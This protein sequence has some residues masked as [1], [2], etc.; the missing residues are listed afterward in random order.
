M[1]GAIARA[2]VSCWSSLSMRIIAPVL[3]TSRPIPNLAL[4]CDPILTRYLLQIDPLSLFCGDD[5]NPPAKRLDSQRL[6]VPELAEPHEIFPVNATT[7]PCPSTSTTG[8]RNNQIFIVPRNPIP[9]ELLREWASPKLVSY[10][11]SRAPSDE[12][13]E[14]AFSSAAETDGDE[15][16]THKKNKRKPW[17]DVDGLEGPA[18]WVKTWMLTATG[19]PVI[20]LT[21]EDTRSTPDFLRAVPKSPPAPANPPSPGRPE[22]HH[23]PTLGDPYDKNA[24]FEF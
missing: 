13:D 20:D 21:A 2:A 5:G 12:P 15:Q 23:D 18:V 4:R 7:S 19:S 24:T 9:T 6:R 17:R 16:I 8:F 1:S 22:T 3:G 11:Q 14:D 10:R